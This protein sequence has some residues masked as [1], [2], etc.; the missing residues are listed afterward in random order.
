MIITRQAIILRQRQWVAS[1]GIKPTAKGYLPTL[2]DNL[3]Q[4]LNAETRAEF[5]AGNG[6]ELGGVGRH[7]RMQAFLSSSALVCNVFDYWRSQLLLDQSLEMLTTALGAPPPINQIQFE[8]IYATGIRDTPPHLD[9]ILLGDNSKPFLIESD[10]AGFYKADSIGD[11]STKSYF[12][13]SGEIW[14]KHGLPR[15][16]DLARRIHAD[17][18]QFYDLNAP[19][20]L[21]HIL[22]LVNTFHNDF[23][24]R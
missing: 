7:G 24:L 21:K 23:T 22:G 17:Q 9:I 20:L 18:E 14:G 5:A 3:F 8:Q 19:L 13:N 11:I 10:F 4:P 1:R 6:N 15:C 2:E 12:P 16:E